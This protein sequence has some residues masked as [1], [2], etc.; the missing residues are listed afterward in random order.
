MKF[1]DI[2]DLNFKDNTP[3]R[4]AYEKD[5]FSTDLL[6]LSIEGNSL[7][8]VDDYETSDLGVQK[9]IETVEDIRACIRKAREDKKNSKHNQIESNL[10]GSTVSRRLGS[11][12]SF[13]ALG[14]KLE[15]FYYNNETIILRVDF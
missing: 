13:S 10:L 7:W 14:H 4:V 2:A 5:L 6:K 11:S 1:K 15:G 8:A 12:L 3:V 9:R